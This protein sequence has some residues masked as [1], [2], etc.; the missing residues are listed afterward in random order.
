MTCSPKTGVHRKSIGLQF[1]VDS[2]EVVSC[3]FAFNLSQFFVLE[4][5]FMVLDGGR[6]G[7]GKKV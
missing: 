7:D 2:D 3:Q 1:F 6:H 5:E 4:E